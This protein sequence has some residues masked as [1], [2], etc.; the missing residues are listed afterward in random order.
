MS[1]IPL[2]QGKVALVD[3]EDYERVM[4]AGPWGLLR[5]GQ[6]LYAKHGAGSKRYPCLLMHRFVVSAPDGQYVD[7][8]Q[9]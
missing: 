8:I 2:T 5:A 9:P 4:A 3:D 6:G 1:E 7:H